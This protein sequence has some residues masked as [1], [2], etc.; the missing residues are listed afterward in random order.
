M[1]ATTSSPR[2][3]AVRLGVGVHNALT[4][5]I[6]ERAGF[7]F[8]WVS[9]EE[10]AARLGLD[11]PAAVTPAELAALTAQIRAVG[12]PPVYADAGH[13]RDDAGA[14]AA[15]LLFERAGAAAICL[16][17]GA[18]ARP[19][20]PGLTEPEA[21]ARRIAAAGAARP[22]ATGGIRRPLAAAGAAGP[23]AMGGAP[24]RRG[25][26]L[27]AATDALLAGA[28]AAEAVQRLRAY[29][30]A[31]ADALLVQ[32]DRGSRHL[33]EPVLAGL[34]GPVPVLLAAS[35]VPDLGVEDLDVEDLGVEDLGVEDLTRL[36]VAEAVFTGVVAATVRASLTGTLRTVRATGRLADVAD[37]IAPV[38]EV[39]DLMIQR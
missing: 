29:A 24:A 32:V 21:A 19:G 30:Q 11:D 2:G 23:L 9:A 4:A 3:S 5:R 13:L 34:R 6:A 16:H 25:I 1:S 10:L 18:P 33:L 12:G 27:I 36:G 8:A 7:D 26:R 17:D 20:T 37:H 31:G 14:A 22:P 38:D 28:P 39:F 15:V 35:A